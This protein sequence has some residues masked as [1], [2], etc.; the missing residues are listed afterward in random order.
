M[1]DVF[2]KEM[3]PP[4]NQMYWVASIHRNTDNVHIHI[5]T[6]EREPRRQS[7]ERNGQKQPKGRRK[8]STI[9]HMKSSFANELIGTNELTKILSIERQKIRK[10]VQKNLATN[11]I[12]EDFQKEINRLMSTLPTSRREWN[13]NKLNSSQQKSL[14]K[15]V[16]HLLSDNKDF[17]DWKNNVLKMQETRV[18]LYGKSKR[19]TK[20]Y[21]SNQMY[22]KEGI[23]ARNGNALLHDLRELDKKANGN[24]RHRINLK[25]KVRPEQYVQSV[26]NEV[27]SKAKNYKNNSRKHSKEQNK[28]TNRPKHLPRITK[29]QLQKIKSNQ[30]KV[31]EKQH[32]DF[33]TRKALREYE[34]MQ[35]AVE[36]DLDNI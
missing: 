13:Y 16:D 4:L 10:A 21:A 34:K 23:Y 15:I 27:Q 3:D 8:Q 19:N 6:V 5:A 25:D 35:R 33:K 11:I 20:N 30:E 31:W 28:A 36:H 17:Q 12:N 9:D 7:I 1:Q 18:A 26:L 14:N 2:E 22:G 32:V 29:K 24:Q